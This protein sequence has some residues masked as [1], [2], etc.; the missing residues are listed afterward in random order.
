MAASALAQA[1]AKFDRILPAHLLHRPLIGVG[2]SIK[3]T[4]L[5]ALLVIASL[6]I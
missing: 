6:K 5:S 2:F 3:K 4:S 1:L